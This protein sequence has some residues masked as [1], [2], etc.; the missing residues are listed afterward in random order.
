MVKNVDLIEAE[1]VRCL[2][3]IHVKCLDPVEKF[4][5]NLG[6]RRNYGEKKPSLSL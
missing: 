5:T 6:S 4:E 3:Q 1:E 2:E